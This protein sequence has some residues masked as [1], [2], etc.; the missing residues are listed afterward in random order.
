MDEGRNIEIDGRAATLK[1][2]D[3]L[4]TMEDMRWD[5]ADHKNIRT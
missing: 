4:K 3:V 1:T 5:W 2:E